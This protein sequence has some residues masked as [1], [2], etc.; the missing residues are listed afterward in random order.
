MPEL[1]EVESLRR[2]LEPHIRGGVVVRAQLL[3]ADFCTPS[4]DGNTTPADLLE[5]ATIAGTL[6]HGKQLAII[7]QD[8]RVMCVHL[9]MSGQ[10]LVRGT[11]DPHPT[12]THAAW[13]LREPSGRVVR[14]L[15]R[16]PRRFGGLWTFPTLD[17]LRQTL[18][19]E[20]GPDALTASP[21]HFEPVA[22]SRRAIKAVLLDQS[23]LAGVGNI[24]ADEALHRA[25]VRPAAAACRLGQPDYV[26]LAVSVREVLKAAVKAGGSTLRDYVNADGEAGWATI[27]HAVYGRQGLPCVRCGATLRHGTI[28]QRTT[29]WCPVCQPLPNRSRNRQVSKQRT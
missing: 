18:W 25:G 5:G 4:H 8:G 6:R 16:D 24:Y 12:H 9:G 10:V 20:L 7:A 14:L 11:D 13:E 27:N 28:G 3:R 21:E 29:V 26:K 19:K 23:V 22:D 2:S 17:A 15:F 1:P